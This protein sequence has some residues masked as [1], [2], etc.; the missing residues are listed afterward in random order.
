M[1]NKF[2]KV[3]TFLRLNQKDFAE[4]LGIKQAYYSAI[5][6]GKR[7]ASA[8]VINA[9]FN[10]NVSPE[11]FYNG[12]GEMFNSSDVCN[13]QNT[14][15]DNGINNTTTSYAKTVNDLSQT[16][17]LLHQAFTWLIV[18][19]YVDNH[20]LNF[21]SDKFRQLAISYKVVSDYL[22]LIQNKMETDITK[23]IKDQAIKGIIEDKEST[24]IS[25]TPEVEQIIEKYIALYN[26]IKGDT[27]N[28]L[29]LMKK[30]GEYK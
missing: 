12:K 30:L 17:D 21:S 27:T 1:S 14:K 4:K 10:L 2:K 11:W 16:P 23:A 13:I 28:L 22:Q 7:D 26:E 18:S 29:G 8:S 24:S 19:D 5:E 20:N 15:S 6:I 25:P 3:R 9:L